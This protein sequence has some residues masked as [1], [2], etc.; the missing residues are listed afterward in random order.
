[1]LIVWIFIGT[2]ISIGLQQ[3][4]TTVIDWL[5]VISVVS[6]LIISL[7][8]FIVL[9]KRRMYFLEMTNLDR[10]YFS[11]SSDHHRHRSNQSQRKRR[12]INQN[13]NQSPLL[14]VDVAECIDKDF[15]FT[16]GMN[17]LL[18]KGNL[19]LEEEDDI[20]MVREREIVLSPTFSLISVVEFNGS[21]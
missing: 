7:V 10:N 3:K 20:Q 16:S 5:P 6:A 13:N 18:S 4:P 11:S 8:A 15:R 19:V 21:I 12:S 1:M 17:V 9:C 2:E 14:T